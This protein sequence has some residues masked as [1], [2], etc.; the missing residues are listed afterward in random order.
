MSRQLVLPGFPTRLCITALWYGPEVAT[1]IVAT[2][3]APSDAYAEVWEVSET[4][5]IF[6]PAELGDALA[7]IA[8]NIAERIL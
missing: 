4:T 5:G 8:L 7:I 3:D 6:T 2:T 1:H